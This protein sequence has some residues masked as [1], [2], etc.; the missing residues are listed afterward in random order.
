MGA[1]NAKSEWENPLFWFVLFAIIFWSITFVNTRSLLS[2]FSALALIFICFGLA[3]EFL[4]TGPKNL[5]V[6]AICALRSGFAAVAALKRR[7]GCV[8]A[9]FRWCGAA[10]EICF[11][12]VRLHHRIYKSPEVNGCC[13]NSLRNILNLRQVRMRS[14]DAPVPKVS[15]WVR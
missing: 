12:S 3:L 11:T 5:R 6:F 7:G 14:V 2:D 9:T 4:G 1:F 10:Q 8:A 13:E 15:L